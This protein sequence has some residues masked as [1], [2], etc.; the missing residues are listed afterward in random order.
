[1]RVPVARVSPIESGDVFTQDV[2]SRFVATLELRA[3]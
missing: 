3:A 2:L 1:M